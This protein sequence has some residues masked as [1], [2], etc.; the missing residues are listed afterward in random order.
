A[1]RGGP[2][3]PP[4]EGLDTL[5]RLHREI[6]A[7]APE[8]VI[9]LGD[10]FDDA[11][12]AQAPDAALRDTLLRLMAGR[13]WVWIL[14]NH[15]PAPPSFGGE[16]RTSLA[17]GP[18]RLRHAALRRPAEPHTPEAPPEPVEI[19]AHY[20]PKAQ[21]VIRGRK[22]SRRCFLWDGARL[23]LP[24]FGAYTGGLPADDPAFDALMG[25][26]ALALVLS[27]DRVLPFPRARR[28]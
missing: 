12:A 27:G 20:H 5:E 26:D 10:G 11:R 23:I 2:L 18:L 15:D 3:L 21:M 13:R 17:L 1:R 22:L 8:M 25:A 9:S 16:A 19:S 7:L 14:G 24:A 4:Y 28:P 6:A